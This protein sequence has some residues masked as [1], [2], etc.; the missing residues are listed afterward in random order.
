M[1]Y[2]RIK[3]ATKA[4]GL[5]RAARW[6]NRHVFDREELARRNADA[7][8][9]KQV[10]RPGE[11]VFDV[12]AN[13][14]EKSAALLEAGARVIAF[15]P[16]P[17]CFAELVSR[18]G[19]NPNLTVLQKAVGAKSGQARFFVRE[20]RGT[21]GLMQQWEGTVES[22]ITVEVTTVQQAIEQYG[23]PGYVK[24][25]VEG[26]E[27]EVLKGLQESVPLISFEY[28]LRDDTVDEARKCIRELG[29]FGEQV[30]IN[31]SPA[32]DLKFALPRWLSPNEFDRFY[33]EG[34]KNIPGCEG[35]GDIF[36]RIKPSARSS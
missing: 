33:P 27:L 36:V 28:H 22:E 17:D 15:E 1:S 19:S 2:E 11:L 6:V 12:G 21:S 18:C 5:Y 7:A 29:R 30:E 3:V 16:Q 23:K 10:L 14:G 31:F 34:L 26:F 13:Y 25:D 35:Y 9:F 8:F 32:E 20:K 24:I 4:L